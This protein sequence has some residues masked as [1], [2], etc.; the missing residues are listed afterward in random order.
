[1]NESLIARKWIIKHT[2]RI[3]PTQ[4]LSK[5]LYKPIEWIEKSNGYLFEQYDNS[6][7]SMLKQIVWTI[8]FRISPESLYNELKRMNHE[9]V[10][11]YNWDSTVCTTIE[12]ENRVPF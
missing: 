7:H 5:S 9:F 12:F 3:D 6:I 1:M 2:K 10:N 11:E 8:G 4:Y